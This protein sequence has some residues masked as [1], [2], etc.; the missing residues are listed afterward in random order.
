MINDNWYKIKI[1]NFG[2]VS[3]L[4]G[5]VLWLNNKMQAFLKGP[6]GSAPA[7]KP[8]PSSDPSSAP[9]TSKK[10]VHSAKKHI[11]WVEK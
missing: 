2:L 1:Y 5:L 4:S 8:P 3:F 6:D 9:G 7:K 11:P 10:D